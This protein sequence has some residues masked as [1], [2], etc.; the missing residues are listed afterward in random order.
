MRKRLGAALIGVVALIAAA[1]APPTF[2]DGNISDTNWAGLVYTHNGPPNN[3]FTVDA[4][5]IMPTIGTCAPGSSADVGLWS[6]MGGTKAAPL[7]NPLPQA[8]IVIFCPGG[9]AI[10]EPA[11][12]G[13]FWEVPRADHMGDQKANINYPIGVSVGDAID[14]HVSSD[15]QTPATYSFTVQNERTGAQYV[16]ASEVQ[17]PL[18]DPTAECIVERSHAELLYFG[19]ATFTNCPF[20]NTGPPFDFTTARYDIQPN[21]PNGARLTQTTTALGGPDDLNVT[22]KW[23]HG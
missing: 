1:C 5:L 3:L 7:P 8:G 10:N 13:A 4:R 19:T 22:V 17:V 23:L 2:T 16:N 9:N 15:Q 12:V 21:P 20:Y 18:T 14:I 11:T 6:G